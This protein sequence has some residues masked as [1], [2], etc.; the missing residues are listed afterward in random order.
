MFVFLHFLFNEHY[1]CYLYIF[2]YALYFQIYRSFLM[3]SIHKLDDYRFRC[4]NGYEIDMHGTMLSEMHIIIIFIIIVIKNNIIFFISNSDLL[5]RRH[6][7][8]G[9]KLNSFFYISILFY[10]LNVNLY[11]KSHHYLVHLQLI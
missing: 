4:F 7:V 8:D 10:Y 9:C 6:D 3:L 5:W 2:M 11:S 1:T